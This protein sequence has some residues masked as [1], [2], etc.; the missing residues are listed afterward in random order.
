MRLRHWFYLLNIGALAVFAWAV[1]ADYNR[2]W[3]K[4]QR[5]YYRR[6]AQ[7]LEKKLAQTSDPDGRKRLQ[8]EIRSW[9]R[10]GLGTKQIIVKDLGRVDRCIT[11]HV[12]M[13]EFTNPSLTNDFADQPYKAHPDLTGLVRSHPFQKFGCTVCHSGQG[14]ATT[15]KA[16][17]EG[18]EVHYGES[19]LAS[20]YL[21][22]PPFIQASCIKCHGDFE[23]L[24]GAQTAALGKKLFD[25][26]GCIGC[27]TLRGWGGVISVELGDIAHKPPE[28][29]APHDFHLAEMPPEYSK[30]TV[31]NWILAHLMRD[32]M[33]F[34]RNDPEGRFN[35]EPIAPSGMPP[36]YL[37]LKEDE[38]KAITTYLLSMTREERIPREYYVYAPPKPEPKLA[39]A[40]ERGRH[41]FH[42]FG[43]QACHGV[44]AKAGRR[45][46]NALGKDQ[47]PSR[48]TDFEEMAK[49]REPTLPDTVGTFT[50]EE[51][52]NKILHGVPATAV[53]R[54][55]P[56]GPLPP[57]YMPS[58]KDKIK[59]QELEDLVTFLQS[60]AKKPEPG[61]EW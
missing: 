19:H 6:T 44:D 49:G 12:G 3:K 27:H 35:P 39:S 4:Y 53:A 42:K 20:Q 43:C 23:K 59:G 32:P 37:E 30:I 58:W 14:L 15:V 54:F 31:Q 33:K 17:H 18:I 21:L 1:L 26:H 13:D 22:K 56:Q 38:A 57:G 2:E 11:C 52:K 47:D 45:N 46:F 28:R 5:E 48:P 50:R 36:F 29:I 51:L 9:R 8:A 40:V 61:E 7:G 41:V 10:R 55:N 24:P 16:A 60:I 25:K 34:V